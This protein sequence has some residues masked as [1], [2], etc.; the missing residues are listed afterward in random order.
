MGSRGLLEP[1]RL[2]NKGDFHT[3]RDFAYGPNPEGG[4]GDMIKIDT[5]VKNMEAGQPNPGTTP[6]E[7]AHEIRSFAR[8][9]LGYVDALGDVSDKT[10]RRTLGDISC[11]ALLGHYYA[12]KLLGAT[13]LRLFDANQRPQHRQAAVAH[14]QSAARHWKQL[15][16]LA[17]A[18]YEP[19][20]LA[21][22]NYLDWQALIP[23]VLE[24]IDIAA[25]KGI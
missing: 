11:M 23:R 20:F 6:V 22:N 19:Q 13:E 3:V 18:Q 5:Y 4:N 9:A 17:S 21:R 2:G 10:V 24:D 14:M 16:Q 15:A 25:G 12:D 7:L 8:A 1:Q